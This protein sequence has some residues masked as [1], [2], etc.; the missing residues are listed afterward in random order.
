MTPAHLLAT[1]RALDTLL[2]EPGCHALLARRLGLGDAAWALRGWRQT[3]GPLARLT[4][5][6]DA[7]LPPAARP[8]ALVS[9][10]D[11][12]EPLPVQ[13][14]EHDG[15]ALAQSW[16]RTSNISRRGGGG[17]VAGVLRAQADASRFYALSAGHVWAGEAGAASGDEVLIGVRVRARLRD[18]TPEFTLGAVSTP[19]DAAI[20]Q[21]PAAD[22]A[23]LGLPGSALPTGTARC[24]TGETL[25][26]MDPDQPVDGVFTELVNTTLTLRGSLLAPYRL[27]DALC[28]RPLRPTQ[29]GQSGGGLWNDRDEWVGLHAGGAEDGSEAY[30]VPI[31]PVLAWAGATPLRRGET[32]AAPQRRSLPGAAILAPAQPP[33]PAAAAPA[34]ADI[35]TLARTLWGEARGEGPAG[36][37]AVAHVV[38]NRVAACSWWGRDVVAVCRQPWQFSCWNANDP[39]AARLPRLDTADADFR[40]ALDAARCVAAAEGSGARRL[41]GGDPTGGA[42]HYYAP[43]VV[44]PPRWARGVTPCARIGRHLFFK[45]IA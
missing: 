39:N 26:L 2:A 40:L 15:P 21:I 20:A 35:D 36:M 25:R 19:L 3:L 43:A 12:A 33:L 32:L 10:W 41:P 16:A 6:V 37:A 5:L 45:D 27:T 24:A 38:F 11:G 18:W 22:M 4:L 42:T 31:H 14:R 23:A 44:A 29:P 1:R 28:W 13:C 17:L 30:A 34:S 9:A 8:R 7:S